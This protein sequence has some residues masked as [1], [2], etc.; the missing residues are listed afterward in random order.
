MTR[1]GSE[2]KITYYTAVV[3]VY[4]IQAGPPRYMDQELLSFLLFSPQIQVR[5]YVCPYCEHFV[6]QSKRQ[7][8]TMSVR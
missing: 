6:L 7:R 3:G 1:R 8:R 4:P 5:P 2:S